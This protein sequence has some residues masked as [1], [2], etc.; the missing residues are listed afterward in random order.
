MKRAILSTAVI[1]ATLAATLA[2]GPA[3]A[4]KRKVAVPHRYDG[5]WS[6]E[7]VTQDGPC[8]RAYRYGVQIERGEASYAGGEFAISGRV[9]ASGGVR[10]VISRGSDRAQVSGQLARSG[11]GSGTWQTAGGLISCSGSWSAVRRG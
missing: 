2:A 3:D 8:D 10:A 11:T 7:V 1:A 4:A 5:R 9:S 6:I